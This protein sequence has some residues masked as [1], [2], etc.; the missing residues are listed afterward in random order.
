MRFGRSLA[1]L[2]RFGVVRATVLALP[3]AV[4]F[5]VSAAAAPV[6]SETGTRNAPTGVLIYALAEGTFDNAGTN[7][8]ITAADFSTTEYYSVHRISDGRLWVQPMTAA[9]LNALASPPP[10]PFTVA[11]TVTM[12]NDEGETA[13][14]TITFST[15]YERDTSARPGEPLAPIFS[16]TGT[17]NAPAGV[18]IYALAEGTFDN[19]G[20]NPRITAADFST[21]EYYSVHRISD[22]RLWVQPMTAAEL[23][24]LPSPPPSPITVAVTV[25]MTND[26]GQTASGTIAFE[27]P[28]ERATPEQPDDAPAPTF[29]ETEALR[30]VDPGFWKQIRADDV[31]D[32]AGT[33]PRITA[34]VFSNTVYYNVRQVYEGKLWVRARSAAEL[35]ALA[36][37]PPSPFTV[38]ADVTMTNDEGRTASGTITFRT[39]YERVTSEQPGEA[40][41]PTFPVTETRS[42][43]PGVLL[44]VLADETFDNAGTNPRIASAVFSTTEYYSVH[45]ISDG[46]LWVQPKTAAELNAMESPP[47]SPFTVDTS[48]T[49]LNDEGQTATGTITFETT[50]ERV[51]SEQP[52]E[53][54]A[55]TFPVTETRNAP[56]GALIHVLADETFD[57]ARARI[58]LTSKHPARLPLHEGSERHAARGARSPESRHAPPSARG[59]VRKTQCV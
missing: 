19:A 51:A 7:P 39:T 8:R 58:A 32:N 45:R 5:A 29:S 38:T 25:T 43:P 16:E 21:T 40:Q 26:E 13:S 57:G 31:F 12:T 1:G 22:G 49:M 23:N 27:T 44:H 48:V 50:Y 20:T 9:E 42:A 14:G 41:T 52:D 33:I 28:Y 4:G 37:P 3:V 55:L 15:P 46:M 30:D 53:A 18:L 2:R 54:A 24:A 36:S 47:L 56:P 34:A 59:R 6:F 11:V 35:S 10:S 17:R